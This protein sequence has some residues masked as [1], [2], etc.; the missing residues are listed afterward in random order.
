MSRTWSAKWNHPKYWRLQATASDGLTVTLG[1]YETEEQA[2]ADCEHFAGH[3]GYRNLMVQQIEPSP[4]P[5]S[6]EHKAP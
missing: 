5:S 6:T 4:R 2:N 3:S 1:R